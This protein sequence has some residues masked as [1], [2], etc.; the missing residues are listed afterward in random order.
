VGDFGR[1]TEHFLE[2]LHAAGQSI[3]QILPL[4]PPGAGESPYAARSTFAGNPLLVSP[5]RLID[6]GL[7]E[8]GEENA[9]PQAWNERVH[10]GEVREQRGRLLRLAAQRWFERGNGDEHADFC[11][12]TAPWLHDYTMFMALRTA[13]GDRSWLEW[14]EAIRRREPSEL[15]RVRRELAP[16]MRFEEF[17]QWQFFRQW[18]T[19]KER[20]V[21]LG[22]RIVGDIPI[23]VDHDSA[24]A[25]ANQDNF[26]LDREGAPEVVAGVPPDYFSETG[27]RWGNPLYRWHRLKDDGYGW[28]VDRLRWTLRQVDMVRLD[29]FRG[30]D[31]AWEIPASHPAV[32][33]AWV[34]GPG[35]D[36]FLTIEQELGSI[37]AIAEDLG[38][39]TPEVTELRDAIGLPGM[40]V[41]Q[42]AFGGDARNPYLPHNIERRSVVYTGTHDNDT[43]AGWL[44]TAS[45]NEKQ[46]MRR[47]LGVDE[48]QVVDLI[49]V[50]LESVAETVILPLQDVLELGGEARMNVPGQADGNW[51]WRFAW[52]DV[53]PWRAAWLRELTEIS[54]RLP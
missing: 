49:R 34:P 50:A 7:L 17:V 41:L 24:D 38:L 45:E 26:K 6:D 1:S 4:S 8:P 53:A 40:K 12:E 37:P 16:E 36:L 54:G 14:P 46:H 9:C 21:S 52:D 5:E 51:G 35:L 27:Q 29:H 31:A 47:Y 44:A 2:F 48:P 15:A 3:W 28:W 20:A 18:R 22:I 19:V 39:I 13:F 25:W 43:T 30:F 11:R 33:G 42:F 10:W 32:D 23:F